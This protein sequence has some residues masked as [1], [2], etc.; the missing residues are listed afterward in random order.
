MHLVS[1]VIIS[2]K[3][4]FLPPCKSLDKG[5]LLHVLSWDTHLPKASPRLPI[6]L[7]LKALWN[8]GSSATFLMRSAPQHQ[9]SHTLP[10]LPHHPGCHL[11]LTPTPIQ[12]CHLPP[13]TCP[14]PATLIFTRTSSLMW[15]VWT[16]FG[17]S[18]L[19]VLPASQA[20]SQHICKTGSPHFIKKL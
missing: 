5:T 6:S 12:S 9:Q 16:C 7:Q 8:L 14:C 17:A 3:I 4:Q 20:L 11:C 13:N 15:L 19:S 10:I 18:A 2:Q 1:K